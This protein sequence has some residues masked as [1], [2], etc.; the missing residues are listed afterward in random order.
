MV[1]T[2]AFYNLENLFDVYDD[3]KTND[4]DFLPNSDKRW[5]YKRY[6][7]KIFKLA[8]SISQIGF[9]ETQKKPSIIGLAEVENKRVLEDLVENEE[10]EEVDYGFVHYNSL[11]ERGV[12]VALMYDKNVFEVNHSETFNVYIE[13]EF[14]EIDFTRDILMVSGKLSG[15]EI[16]VIVNHWPSRREGQKESEY[17]RVLAASKVLEIIEMIRAQNSDPKIIIMGDFN[18]NPNNESIQRLLIEG[19]LFNPMEILQSRSEGS[20]N[21]NFQWNLFDQIMFSTNFIHHDNG[22]LR[23]YK[24]DIFNKRFLTQYRGKYKGQP[25]RTYVGKK[26]M[27]GYSDHFPVYTIMG[28]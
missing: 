26:Y 10:F 21:Y 14:G 19:D 6:N 3:P 7:K 18:D 22:K 13:N 24:A 25:F 8:L 4:N 15:E 11:D 28:F 1:H 2:I 20:Q 27:G 17:K 16:F 12:D 9:D 23:F 5:T